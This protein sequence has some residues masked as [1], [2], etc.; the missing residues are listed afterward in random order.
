M[1]SEETQHTCIYHV[2]V[3]FATRSNK[4]SEQQASQLK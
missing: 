3:H 4:C 1:F 2:Y